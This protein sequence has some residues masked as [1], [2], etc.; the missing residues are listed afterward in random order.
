MSN[1]NPSR[2]GQINATGAVDALFL[3]KFAGEVL[4][5]Y[6]IAK[7]LKPT[8][9]VRT[10]DSGKSAQFPATYRIK[11]GYHTPGAELLGDKI[12]HQE[13]VVTL[14]DL[15]IA[16][17]FVARIDELKN[18]YDV[19]APYSTELGRALAL[20]EDRTI[21]QCIVKAARGPE[22]F[23]GDGGGSVVT[24]SSVSATAD[25]TASGEDLISAFN[26]AK[27]AMD[28]KNV[29]VDT[30]QV[31]GVVKPAQW[32]LMANSDKN[33]NRDFNAGNDASI[34][35]Q[36][37]RTVS[38]ILIIK[39]NAVLFG[40]DATVYDAATNTDGI[41]K[42]ANG[43]YATNKVSEEDALP[44]EWPSKYHLDLTNTVGAV[45]VEPAVAYLQLLGLNMETVWDAR[46]RG[47][48]LIAEMAIGMDALRTKC[49]VELRID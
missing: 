39:S 36:A 2:L 28:S 7:K 14:D 24:E 42:D 11:A 22:L 37:L 19:R 35:R 41:V 38:D 3:K 49:A 10:I 33:L 48:L 34:A 46:R 26:K 47:T 27:E 25:F 43:N 8:V 17:T 32:Y 16:H 6:D 15:M 30:M 9:R 1:A 13:I 4:T 5:A 21:A 31:Y 44:N 20:L 29:P 45:W 40:L 12:K 23:A 18:H